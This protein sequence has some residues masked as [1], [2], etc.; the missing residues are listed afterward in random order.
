MSLLPGPAYHFRTARQW[1]CVHASGLAEKL[2]LDPKSGT[3]CG[4]IDCPAEAVAL[5]AR[6]DLFWVDKCHALFAAGREIPWHG[7]EGPAVGRVARLVAGKE[8]LW[9][10]VDCAAPGGRA[11]ADSRRLLQIDSRSLHFLIN[12]DV[13]DVVDIAGDGKDG[14]WLL[15]ARTLR[16]IS[17]RGASVGRTRALGATASAIAAADGRLALLSE[18]GRGILLLDPGSGQIVSLDLSRLAGPGW[19]GEHVRISG[20][21]AAFLIDG[22]I[23]AEPGFLLLDRDGNLLA[24]GEWRDGQAPDLLA[25][26]GDDLVGLFGEAGG[27]RLRLYAGLAR[28]GSQRRMTPRLETISP[29]GT[30]LRAEITAR[31]PERATLSLR[32]AA[33][34]DTGLAEKVEHMLA[35]PAAPMTRRLERVEHLLRDT[36]SKT[37]TYVGER[38]EGPAPAERF[39]FPLHA[40]TGP[41]LWI[42]LR[43]ARNSA[44]TAPEIDTLLVLHEAESLMDDL[45]AIYKGDGDR[46]GTMRRLVAVLETTTQGMDHRIARLAARLDPDQTSARWLPDLAAMLGLPFHDALSAEMQRRLVKA[47]PSILARRGT[48]LGL[49]SMLEA[50]FPGR[51]VRVVDRTEQLIPISLGRDG[52]GG[53]ALPAMLAGPS[54]RVPRLNARLV[55][56]KTGLCK[57]DACADPLIAPGPEILV[58]IPARGR[59][60]QRY[61]DAVAQM[62]EAMVPAGVRVRLRWT[63]WRD[64]GATRPADV[65]TILDVPERLSLGVGPALGR[66]RTGGRPAARLDGQGATP[67]NHRLL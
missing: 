67:A 31:L 41:L 47:A 21:G 65:L 33:T 26:A 22:N 15:G 23:G 24:R 58:S 19:S 59:E 49:I 48:R 54:I 52:V 5:S 8:R 53:R 2:S 25:A 11:G 6:G 56:N 17:H 45:P 62:V 16:R 64:H 35:D 51:P 14:L 12:R 29:A 38:H 39:A 44:D 10:L 57:T 40:A 66:A 4:F 13:G 37:F 28:P 61:R 43:I 32:W 27:Q 18:D 36:W 55:L 20:A 50:L 1:A 46:D 34:A 42:D 3:D 60:Q 9:A 63:P 7:V 30:W